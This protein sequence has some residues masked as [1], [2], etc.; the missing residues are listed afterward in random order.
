MTADVDLGRDV[1]ARAV[2]L[3]NDKAYQD[4]LSLLDAFRVLIAGGDFARASLLVNRDCAFA[5]AG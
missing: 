1:V 2:S 5:L 3:F 4:A